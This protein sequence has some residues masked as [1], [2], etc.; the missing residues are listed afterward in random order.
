MRLYYWGF[1]ELHHVDDIRDVAHAEEFLCDGEYGVMICL[2]DM[3]RGKIVYGA[4]ELRKVILDRERLIG[5]CDTLPRTVV[6]ETITPSGNVLRTVQTMPDPG[7]WNRSHV[8]LY[9]EQLANLLAIGDVLT[10][11]V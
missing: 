3:E 6:S 11:R 5:A 10:P 9:R 4:D 1:Y 2:V 8:E 7:R